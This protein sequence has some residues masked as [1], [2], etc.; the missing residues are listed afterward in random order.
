MIHSLRYTR[1]LQGQVIELE[2]K[3]WWCQEGSLF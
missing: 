3:F 2:D 1:T